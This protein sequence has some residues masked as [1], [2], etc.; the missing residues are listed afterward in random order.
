[1]EKY[2]FTEIFTLFP[3][4]LYSAHAGEI[5]LKSEFQPGNGYIFKEYLYKKGNVVV[6]YAVPQTALPENAEELP[7]FVARLLMEADAITSYNKAILH[8]NGNRNIAHII[9]CTG[10]ELKL[11]NS[12]KADSFESALYFL[13]LAIKGLQMNP[14]QCTVRVCCNITK[15]QEGIFSRFFKGFQ[16][17]DLDIL[18][19][20]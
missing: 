14:R 1:M 7:P 11:A 19:K 15:E 3:K 17:N 6:S 8:Y 10:E 2:I 13:F 18:L 9:I 20:K 12:F 4:E 16:V 5:A